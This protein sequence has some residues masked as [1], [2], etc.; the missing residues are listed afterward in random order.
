RIHRHRRQHRHADR[1]V[2]GVDAGERRGPRARA[3]RALGP[4]VARLARAAPRAAVR[5]GAAASPGRDRGHA[6]TGGGSRGERHREGGGRRARRDP[7]MS[8]PP[9]AAAAT[10]PLLAWRTRFPSVE[11]VLHFASHTLGAMP[12]EAE[13]A[14]VE[15]ASLW[16][17]RG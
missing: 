4:A 2:P 3:D 7:G 8:T 13:A 15:Y 12:A 5:A 6:G 10:D 1:A 14:L 9:V 16:G 17:G 11:S